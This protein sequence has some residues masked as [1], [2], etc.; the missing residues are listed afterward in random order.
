MGQG[1][2]RISNNML[3]RD[4]CTFFPARIMIRCKVIEYVLVLIPVMIF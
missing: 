1:E 3:Q 2:L 4:T